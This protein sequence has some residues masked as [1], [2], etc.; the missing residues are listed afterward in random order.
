MAA[1]SATRQRLQQGYAVPSEGR[2]APRSLQARLTLLAVLPLAVAVLL[3]GG[4]SLT[5]EARTIEQGFA[6]LGNL[7]AEQC[8]LQAE[9]AVATGNEALMRDVLARTLRAADVTAAELR[10]NEGQLLARVTRPGEGAGERTDFLAQIGLRALPEGVAPGLALGSD[11]P[12]GVARVTLSRGRLHESLAAHWASGL[13]VL[14][15]GGLLAGVLAARVAGRLARPLD[16]L[17]DAARAIAAG[18]LTRRVSADA[19]GEID[20]LKADFN[21][22]AASLADARSDLEARIEAATAGLAARSRALAAA[23]EAKS[24]FLATATHDLRQPAQ[25]IALHARVLRML[26]DPSLPMFGEALAG[27]TGASHSL[28]QLLA[29]LDDVSRLDAGRLE[30]RREPLL[31]LPLLERLVN[32]RRSAA[33]A[34]GTE[35]RLRRADG[36]ALGDAAL[37]T[38]LVGNLLDNALKFARGG[39]V[40][41]AVRW[42]RAGAAIEVRDDGPGIAAEDLDHIFEEFYQARTARAQHGSGMGLG[43]AI[44]AR[45]AALLGG[46]LGVASRPGKGAAFR[47]TLPP[48]RGALQ[49][50]LPGAG[51]APGNGA[52]I[53]LEDDPAVRSSLCLALSSAGFRVEAADGAGPLPLPEEVAAI[54]AD[55]HLAGGASGIATARALAVRF[56]PPPA[57]IVITG[58][59]GIAS[60]PAAAEGAFRVLLKPVSFEVLLG[61][62]AEAAVRVGAGQGEPASLAGQ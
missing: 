18:D 8:A 33:S 14:L 27:L 42:C 36:V 3:L 20:A 37:I 11:R 21:R 56:Q 35:L 19:D 26:R 60:D 61:V 28:T 13:I 5:R 39:R 49:L 38:R 58:D 9:L 57:I 22:M 17:A 31:L 46:T 25:A 55:Y 62:L 7:I 32:T 51:G 10:G 45:L 40:L 15:G 44:A 2:R 6:A 34:G 48:A 54:V 53:V 16:D 29:A 4:V 41:V 50:P 24:R 30:A 43:L 1:S 23:N 52:V 12:L 59:A 47:L